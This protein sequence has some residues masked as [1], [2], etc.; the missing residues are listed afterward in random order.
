MDYDIYFSTY[1]G[2]LKKAKDV[3]ESLTISKN[4]VKQT[5]WLLSKIY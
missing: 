2:Y 3:N 1:S 5:I 4:E